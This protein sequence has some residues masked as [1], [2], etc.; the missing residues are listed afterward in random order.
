MPVKM[1]EKQLQQMLLP[2]QRAAV[3]LSGG[4]DSVCLLHMVRGLAHQLSIELMAV[5]VHHGLRAEADESFWKKVWSREEKINFSSTPMF[6]IR[7]EA[8]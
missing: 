1:V 2:G 8:V 7:A 5:H 6:I 4:R 3:A